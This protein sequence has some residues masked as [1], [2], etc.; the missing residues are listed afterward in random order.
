MIEVRCQALLKAPSGPR[1]RSN[2]D[3]SRTNACF[4][5]QS[6]ETRGIPTTEGDVMSFSR[7]VRKF[8]SIN[9]FSVFQISQEVIKL[10]SILDS[11]I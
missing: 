11:D 1:T 6:F 2:K 8:T 4:D 9:N 7:I 5:L 3:T 10:G